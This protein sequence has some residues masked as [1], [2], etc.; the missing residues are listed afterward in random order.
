MRDRPAHDPGKPGAAAQVAA[1]VIAAALPAAQELEQRQQR[2]P[3][4]ANG[5]LDAGEQLR[6]H[7]LDLVGADRKR[8]VAD[9][10]QVGLEELGRAGA[11]PRRG[12]A[13]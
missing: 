6:A 10:V 11:Q 4:T 2:Q 5:P 8:R 3:S 13:R 1:A 7:A 12:T 9:R